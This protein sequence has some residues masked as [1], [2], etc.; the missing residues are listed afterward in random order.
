M[1]QLAIFSV[2]FYFLSGLLA[3]SQLF[4]SNKKY[5][6]SIIILT[7]LALISHAFWLYQNILLVNGQN[8]PI[9]NV[10]SL[11]SFAIATLLLVISKKFNT[12]VLLPIV[13]GFNIINFIAVIYLPS[14]YIT[15]LEHN[16]ELGSHVLL[17]ILAYAIMTIASLFA[18]QLAYVDYRLKKHKS[19]M[20]SL[21]LPPLMTLEKSLFQLILI[22]FVL[23][24]GT[25]TTGIIF[26]EDMFAPDN[27]HK[28]VFTIIA[29][30]IYAVLLWGRY[31]K[32]WRGRLVIYITI[33]GSSALTLAYFGSRVVREIIL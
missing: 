14:H 21:N 3:S 18:L 32:G 4:S 23:L 10:L 24:T 11:V 6:F 5:D 20:V 8:L 33:A 19:L 28:T 27:A 17:A 15:H 12:G 22:G 31:Q 1:I 25:L 29:W 13:H 9:L 26:L 7:S 2:I 16:P 30:C